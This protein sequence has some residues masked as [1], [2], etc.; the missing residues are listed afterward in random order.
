MSQTTLDDD[1]FDEAAAEV[2]ADV[3]E[4]LEGAREALPTVDDIWDLEAENTLGVLNAL[5]SG[6]DVE[7]PASSL[8]DAKKW[9]AMGKRADAFEDAEDLASQID[10]IEEV[11][12]DLETAH[13]AVGELTKTLPEL[14][15][16]LDGLGEDLDE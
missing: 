8:R 13:E 12:G 2:R 15:A 1:L 3:E 7:E 5:R 10:E 9:Y 16:T 14:R 11:L 6:L 4:H